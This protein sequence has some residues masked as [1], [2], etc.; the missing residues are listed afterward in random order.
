MRQ[1][2]NGKLMAMPVNNLALSKYQG[3]QQDTGMLLSTNG[4]QY[5]WS[6]T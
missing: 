6:A 4:E 1:T 2:L 5:L 3:T